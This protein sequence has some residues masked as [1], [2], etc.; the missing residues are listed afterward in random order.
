MS[1]D[2]KT[3]PVFK[4]DVITRKK[5]VSF[6]MGFIINTL[7]NTSYSYFVF[8][9][10]EVELGLL[11]SLVAL[12]YAIFAIWNMINDPLFGY[13]TDKPRKWSKKYGMRT[14]WIIFGGIGVIICFYFL[15]AVPDFGDVKSNPWPLFWYMIIIT[16]LY[17]TFYT[18]FTTHYFG[19]FANIFRTPEERRKGS[20][21]GYLIGLG[22]RTGVM[23]IL[24]P[25]L[26][27]R[28]DPS[29]YA[30][31]A[32]ILSIVMGIL[33]ILIIPG[34]HEN[35]FVKNRYLQIYEFMEA[36]RLPAATW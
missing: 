4:K 5:T 9:Y 19:G 30:R 32:L 15:F 14:P 8:Y 26:I 18:I 13:L 10:Y 24:I 23:I 29:S 20:S 31:A 1:T 36:T 7:L 33:L 22:A 16:C 2:E 11:T 21:I 34:I 6:S 3:A 28:G 17:D 12:S 27:I 35:E 25:Q